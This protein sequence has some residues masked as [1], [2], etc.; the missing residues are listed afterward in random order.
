MK[1]KYNK[2]D[3]AILIE[4]NDKVI[5]FAEQSGDFIVHFS[6]K[7]EPVLIEI[8]D[9]SQFLKNISLRLPDKVRN[10]IFA[11]PSFGQPQSPA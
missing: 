11:S 2:E 8:L 10:Q 7:R 1:F 3:D 5:D 6:A 4:L 9:A